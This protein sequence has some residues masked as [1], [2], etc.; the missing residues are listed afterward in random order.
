MACPY[1]PASTKVEVT[2][3]GTSGDVCPYNPGGPA[4]P[5]EKR[6]IN[7]DAN[8]PIPQPPVH[9]FT[10]NISELDPA[11]P[12]AAVWRLAK[13]YGD[14][15][16]LDLVTREAVIISSYE[17]INEV[18]DEDR[19]EKSVS[20]GLKEVRALAGDGLFTAYNDEPVSLPD[21]AMPRN[22]F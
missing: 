2:T 10:G 19:F 11:F 15:Y 7:E 17:L 12:V 6:I 5:K 13:I 18:M 16:K 20:G 14:I 4:A 1:D 9:W 22:V 8:E 3:T 21:L